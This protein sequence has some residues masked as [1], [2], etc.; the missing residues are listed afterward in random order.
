VTVDAAA[1]NA[2]AG[3][4]TVTANTLHLGQKL[5]ANDLVVTTVGNI[6]QDAADTTRGL[7]IAGNASFTAGGHSSISLPNDGNSFGG[8]VSFHSSDPVTPLS[9]VT[10]HDTSDFDIQSLTVSGALDVKSVNGAITESGAIHAQT[11]T[12]RAAGSISLGVPD[13]PGDAK[14]QT[15]VN[16]ITS[17]GSVTAGSDFYLYNQGDLDIVG[18][19]QGQT[20]IIRTI[21]NLTLD[22]TI[23][24][25]GS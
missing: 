15:S 14:V 19:V 12:A 21:G 24:G 6:S 13:H 1:L 7:A 3:N 5:T 23:T 25:T 18:A 22:G 16:S 17:L 11:L 8:A 2:G 4:V 9:S 20:V 10:V